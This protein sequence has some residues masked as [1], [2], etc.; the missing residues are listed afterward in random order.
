VEK[1][2]HGILA[3]GGDHNIALQA[4]GNIVPW[5]DPDAI[6][7]PDRLSNIVAFAPPGV[8]LNSDGAVLLWNAESRVIPV[9]SNVVALASRNGFLMLGENTPPD[10]GFY[11]LLDYALTADSA[12]QTISCSF[13]EFNNDPVSFRIVSLPDKGRL[14]QDIFDAA[15]TAAAKGAEI[16]ATN[17][18]LL[19]PFG[20]VF[21]EPPGDSAGSRYTAW[22]YVVSDGEFESLA[23]ANISVVPAQSPRLHLIPGKDTESSRLQFIGWQQIQLPPGMTTGEGLVKYG[24][25][26]GVTALEPDS[27][28]LLV[29]PDR[30]MQRPLAVQSVVPNDPRGRLSNQLRNEPSLPTCG[31][32]S[33][34]SSQRQTRS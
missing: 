33:R 22:T 13:A 8:A 4:D 31:R 14:Y 17:T 5:G 1:S 3:A 30:S 6:Y 16:K 24:S 10:A 19:D 12:A 25:L 27:P 28:A 9:L 26:P 18:A 32:R 34:A 23:T 29:A 11:G 21:Y 7:V 15:R 20:F 2:L